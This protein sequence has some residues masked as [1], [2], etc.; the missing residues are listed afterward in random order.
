M[1]CSTNHDEVGHV[2]PGDLVGAVAEVAVGVDVV[3]L[4]VQEQ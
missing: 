2:A 4:A 1:S 3:L